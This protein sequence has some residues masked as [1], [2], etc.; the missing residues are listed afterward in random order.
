VYWLST[1]RPDGRPHVTPLLGLWL[2]NAFYFCTGADER[3]ARNLAHNAYCVVTTGC[4][5]LT[6]GTDLVFEGKA[7]WIT[8]DADL[9]RLAD[10]YEAKYGSDWRFSVRNGAFEHAS[11]ALTH[12]AVVG[13]AHV[14]RVVPSTAFGFGKDAAYGQT[15]WRW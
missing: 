14:F 7:T 8:D 1:V 12:D 4:N 2:D 11:A 9:Q 3:K 13:H 15:R 10:A 5:R 6:E